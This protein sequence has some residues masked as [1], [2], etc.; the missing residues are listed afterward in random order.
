[1]RLLSHGWEDF[2]EQMLWLMSESESREQLLSEFSFEWVDLVDVFRSS[3]IF[4]PERSDFW[5]T[6]VGLLLTFCTMKSLF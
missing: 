4:K 2:G 6:R 1:M 3:E 5:E